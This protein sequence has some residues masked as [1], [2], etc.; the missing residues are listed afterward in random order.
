M[1]YDCDSLFHWWSILFWWSDC[2]TFLIH[3]TTF[4]MVFSLSVEVPWWPVIHF[5]W[6]LLFCLCGGSEWKW[7]ALCAIHSNSMPV[8]CCVWLLRLW[9]TAVLRGTET[10]GWHSGYSIA[11]TSVIFICVIRLAK[12]QCSTSPLIPWQCLFREG[13]CWKRLAWLLFFGY[14]GS[15]WLVPSLWLTVCGFWLRLVLWLVMTTGCL[16]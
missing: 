3:F 13:P 5:V 14:H 8:C 6:L 11:E 12:L 15:S 10:T 1:K 2:C 7:W 4:S 9:R 16:D